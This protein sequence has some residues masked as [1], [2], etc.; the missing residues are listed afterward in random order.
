AQLVAQWN[1]SQNWQVLGSVNV[2]IGPAGTEYGGVEIGIEELT[3]SIGPSV[4]AQLAW[5]F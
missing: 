1:F 2:P 3:L 5:Y 4:F